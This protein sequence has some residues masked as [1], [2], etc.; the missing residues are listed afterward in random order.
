MST[1]QQLDLARTRLSFF[2]QRYTPDHPEVKS[3]ERTIADLSVRL[4]SEAS[5][6]STEAIREKP[7]T[8]AE[9]AQQKRIRDFEA[10]LAVLD[11]QL[12]A[13]R[14]EDARLKQTITGYQTKVDAVPTRESELVELTRDY[15]TMQAAYASLLMKRE[16][17]VI[18]ANL[19]R[20]QIGEQ[21]RLVDVAS[22]PERPD[23]QQERMMVMASGAAVGLALGL[24]TVG[25]L[26][27][28]DSS[29]R[30]AEEVVKALSLPV[31]ASIPAMASEASTPRRQTAGTPH[32]RR[33]N[34]TPDRCRC[35]AGSVAFA[36][37]GISMYE[38]FYGLTELPF[39][40]TADPKYLFLTKGQREALSNLQYGLLSA[41]SLTLL[42]GEAGTGKT[43]LIRA[44][45]ESERCRGVRCIYLNNPVLRADEFMRLLALKFDLGADSGE[46]KSLLLER[47][48][49]L[50][51]ERRA[52][53]EI[54]ALV[55]DE[56][57]SLSVELLEEVRL[58]A[59]IETP[60]A[61]LLPL[62]LAGQPELA[63]RLEEANLRQL[64]QR[65]TL[66]CELEPFE[67]SDTAAYIASRIRTAGGEPARVFSRDAVTLIHQYS[68]G[69][70]RTI[71]VICD[72]ALITGMALGNKRV[73]QANSLRGVPGSS[74]RGHRTSHPRQRLS[75]QN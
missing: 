70:P 57:Q 75:A 59:N 61:K 6:S 11:Y 56:A 58:L 8:P 50:L 62:V 7:L 37:V 60:S 39:E 16:D 34:G 24:L 35:S 38:H 29:F 22:R 45:L 46:S 68:S 44:A 55:I 28:R 32:R 41:R 43:T 74:P 40:L 1:S 19:E 17:S 2:L 52:A 15:S 36:V 27:N 71:S 54:T 25:L 51:R 13:N 69:I 63:A 73:T 21:F 26:E 23:N 65:V 66:R 49:R 12:A 72:N 5:S 33:R 42:I 31:F 3:L 48:E 18:A 4:E 67:L 30:R 64:K 20:R 9:A 14:A 53:G 10:E 47:L